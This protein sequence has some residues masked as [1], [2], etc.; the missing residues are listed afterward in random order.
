MSPTRYFFGWYVVAATFALLFCGFGVAYSFGAFFLPLANTFS[1][2]RAEVSAVFAYAASLIFFT[3][4][5]TGQLADKFG[6]RRVVLFGVLAVI[7][8]LIASARATTLGGVTLWFTL[9]VGIGVG[10]IY[11]P[12]IGTVQRWFVARRALASGIAVTGI[13]LGTIAMPFAAGIALQSMSWRGVFLCMAVLVGCLCLPAIALLVADPRQRG[14][15]PDG[16]SEPST[17]T[18]GDSGGSW[19]ELLARRDFMQLYAAQLLMS[20]VV[21]LPFVHLVPAAEDIG[22]SSTDAVLLLGM[23]GV[24]STLG[25]IAIGGVADRFGR[26]PSLTLLFAAS[27]AAYL[28]WAFSASFMMLAIF[29]LGYGTVYGGFIAL[30]PAILADYFAGPRLSSIIGIQYTS[31]AF[32][33]LGGPIVAGYIFDYF[34]SYRLAW[35]AAAMLCL[36]AA[37]LIATMPPAG[38]ANDN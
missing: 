9:G 33:S 13:G 22:V 11:V 14:L 35:L 30:M 5:V 31:A 1:A 3:G 2:S 25:R 8:G 29:A 38:R 7:S 4:A 12:S 34:G 37:A 28:W 15:L 23:V 26:G 27:A 16:N 21:L 32:G 20:F 18:S 10:F 19:G 17:S 6:P 36:G 24:G